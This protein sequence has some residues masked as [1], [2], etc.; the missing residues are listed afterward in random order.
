MPLARLAELRL[1]RPPAARAI[2]RLSVVLAVLFCAGTQAVELP[3]V[4]PPGNLVTDYPGARVADPYRALEDLS[5]PST[6]AW[7]A[8]QAAYTRTQLDALPGLQPLRERI[9]ALDA[10][11]S[12]AIV[13]LDIARSGAWFYL[14]REPGARVAKLYTRASASA[15]ER[16]LLDPEKWEKQT[17]V[18]H[19]INNIAASPDG[20]HV[21][22]VV[23]KADAE[24]GDLRVFS[25]KDG[26]DEMPPVPGIWGEIPGMWLPDSRGL[27]YMRGADALTPGGAAFGKMQAHLRRLAGGEDALLL[28]AG[29]ATAAMGPQIRERDWVWADSQSNPGFAVLQLSDG[30][31][32]NAR[33]M[34]APQ[35]ALLKPTAAAAWQTLFG[36]DIRARGVTQQ[37]PWVYARSAQDAP[38]YQVL[39]YDLRAPT[40][41]PVAVVPQQVGVIDEI[42]A[43]QDGLYYI[44]RQGSVSKLYRLP[45]G[46]G[47]DKAAQVQLPF[48]GA[49]SFLGA[50]PHRPGVVVT[51]QG[52]T[53][54]LQAYVVQDLRATA[55]PLIPPDRS[56][57][58]QDW[59]SEEATCTSHDGVEVPMSLI[60][61]KGLA[62]DG[63]HMTVLD[64]YGGYGMAE[65]AYFNR[66]LDPWL[67]RGGIWVDVK[68]RGGGAYGHEWYQAGVGATK[69]NTWKD[70]IACAKAVVARG[71]TR[72][73]KLAIIG[74]SMGGVAVGRAIT[75]APELFAAAVVRVGITDSVRFVEATDNGP[76]HELEMGSVKTEAGMR[77]LLAMS[78]YEHVQ[79]GTRYPA[80]LFTT[81]MNDKRV[82]PWISFKTFARLSAATASGA[83]VLLRVETAGGHGVSQT[84]EQRNAELADV[85][86]FLAWNLGDPGFQPA[87]SMRPTATAAVPASA[88]N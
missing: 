56:G 12:P 88:P 61:K 20:R 30:V 79:P 1:P 9:Q 19:S 4:A 3:P 80:V 53:K 24:L 74:T 63:S 36:E 52:W 41:P 13:S 34:F 32:A 69:P 60:Y 76:N 21:A 66:K 84:A 72:K 77:Q 17:G 8:A 78:T 68:P 46:A 85:F 45:H 59:V 31:G 71:Y 14:K 11:R 18:A 40:Q 82:A 22:A 75:E 23:S 33:V 38:R 83:P 7:A 29:Q 25:T 65:T 51:L 35:E 70:M 47:V 6:Q 86:A 44:V 42:T 57:I 62:K 16:L 10:N 58:G 48:E 26:R 50:Q 81:G 43:V 15:P 5:S 37:G 54:A 55:S 67:Q 49:V 87:T 64:G 27:I 39:R 28:G 2:S 73:D